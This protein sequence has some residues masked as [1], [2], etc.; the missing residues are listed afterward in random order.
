MK[1]YISV[2]FTLLFLVA[3]ISAQVMTKDTS[4]LTNKKGIP[5]LPKKGDFAFGVSANPFLDYL[6]NIFNNTANNHFGLSSNTIYGKY[7]LEDNAAVRI[8]Y[9]WNNT[10]Q[11]NKGY[12]RDDAA[13]LADP[14]SQAQVEDTYEYK[15]D[16]L[17]IGLSYQKYRGY[18]R[19]QGFY[20]LYANYSQDRIQS[21]YSYGN[22][23]TEANPDP[24]NYW[25]SG[26]GNG[27]R[28]LYS[29]NGIDRSL[30]LGLLGGVEFFFMPKASIGAEINFGYSYD[31]GTQSNA[32]YE[33]WDGAQVFE[34][35]RAYS[36]GS[37]SSSFNTYLPS[38]YGG[39]FLMFH[40]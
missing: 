36:P 32:K 18:G 7:Y 28:T 30:G 31:W 4:V 17:G 24:T 35:K 33:M 20:G 12:V 2:L 29:D 37:H 10:H 21:T 1:K 9:T 5:I 14:L 39:L 40:F 16:A 19:L 13:R 8:Y 27:G 25:G 26:D 15:S 22:D 23:I 34:Y 3:S 38:T 6:G 11:I